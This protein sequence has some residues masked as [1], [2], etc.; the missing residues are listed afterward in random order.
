[1]KKNLLISV[2]FTIVTTVLVG[3]IYPLAVT[4]LSQMLFHDI[5]ADTDGL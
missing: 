2:W 3:L 5:G 4:G 1:M